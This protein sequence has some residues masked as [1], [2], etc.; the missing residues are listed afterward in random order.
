MCRLVPLPITRLLIVQKVQLSGKIQISHLFTFTDMS[1]CGRS[2]ETSLRSQFATL[3]ANFY[4][5][6]LLFNYYI[7]VKQHIGTILNIINKYISV[8]GKQSTH[9]QQIQR[10]EPVYK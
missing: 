4:I 5:T 3:N 6:F 2:H 7:T 10:L 8:D 1:L 9:N